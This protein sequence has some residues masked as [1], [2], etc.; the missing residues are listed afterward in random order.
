MKFTLSWL[1]DHLQTD[2]T[3]PQILDAMTMAGLEVEHVDNHAEKL[4]GFSVAKIVEAVQHPNADRLRVCQVDTKDGRKEIVCGAPNARPGLT[5]IYAPLGTFIPGSGITLEPRAV[6]GV[7]SNGMLCSG[8]EL[9]LNSDSNGILELPD[10][11]P[12]G[13]PAAEALGLGDAVID[14]EVTPNRPDWLGV[15]GIARELAAAGLGTLKDLSVAPVPG[16]FACPIPI[17]I[18]AADACPM[19][20]GRLIAGVKNGPS[21]D[22]LQ[23]RLKSIGLR[24]INALVDVTNLLCFDRARPLHVFDA[25]RISGTISARLAQAGESFAALDGKTYA[26]GPEMCVIADDAGVLGLAGVMGGEASGC[27][28]ATTYVFI[29]SAWFDPLRTFQTGRATGINSDAKYRFERGVDPG[30]VL[31][32][33]ELATRLILEICGGEASE[34]AVAGAAPAGRP[35]VTFR[36]S[37][38]SRLTGLDLPEAEIDTILKALGF[39]PQPAGEGV[40]I[41]AVPSWRRD[42]EGPADLVEDVARIA[43]FDRLPQ[44]KLPEVSGWKAGVLTPA[45]NR[46]RIARRAIAGLGYQEA[47]T[48]SFC[49][50]RLAALFGGG[51]DALVLA[52][53]IA[54]D[55]DCMRPSALI[56]LLLAGQRNADRGFAETA[57]FE[58]GPIYAG[59]TPADQATAAAGV[60]RGEA[61]HWAGTAAPDVFTVKADVLA[62][63]EALGAPVASLQTTQGARGWWHPGQSG[64]L[65]LG[66]K[67][68]LAEFGALHPRVLKAMGVAGPVYGFEITLDTLPQAKAKPGKA[69]GRLALSALQPLTRDFAFLLPADRPA[70]ELARA[71]ANADKALIAGVSVFDVYA[72]KGVPD[73]QVSIA[74]QA[75][76]QPRDKTL[77]DAEIEDLSR[78]I[79]AAAAKQGATLRG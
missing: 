75:T 23:Q 76:I 11:L 62:I 48:W 73:G 40:R 13:A 24:P 34:I 58:V 53:P 29:E 22:W 32:G 19:F 37:E 20:A 33:L 42:V 72:G 25:A 3:L 4:A 54:S 59:D 56:H 46:A 65:R 12:V 66:P 77:T 67:T 44:E 61:R 70:G 45:Q 60:V 74:L 10:S 28:E 49:E 68:I 9:E 26:V 18:A 43:G 51:A 69:K 2:A 1:K 57:L 55:L 8:A 36:L 15:A 16:G 39:D 30:F 50:R 41:V 52:N 79:I 27:T 14:F 6:R 35:P 71:I 17:R 21:P 7:V 31:D 47:V 5:T 78:R 64:T 63:L 38:V